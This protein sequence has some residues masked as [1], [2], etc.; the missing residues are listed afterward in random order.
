MKLAKAVTLDLGVDR[1]FLYVGRT[2]DAFTLNEIA[3]FFLRRALDG[4]TIPAIALEVAGVF[5]VEAQQALED[6]QH[7][8]SHLAEIGAV[9]RDE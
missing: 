6:L 9:R 7:F 1:G 2:G 3:V 8:A 4:A 5:A